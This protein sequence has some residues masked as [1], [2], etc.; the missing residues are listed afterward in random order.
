MAGGLLEQQ[1]AGVGVLQRRGDHFRSAF[2]RRLQ[3]V[4]FL[5]AGVED[6]ARG[7]DPVADP[8]RVGERGQRLLPQLFVFGRAVDQV[9]GV[10][11]HRFDLGGVHRLAEGGEI[12][13]AVVG[14]PPHARALV[15]DLDRFATALL[16][17]LD[18]VGEAAGGGNVRSDRT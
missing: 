13:L 5:R 18:R 3:R 7:A 4:G 12:L 8:Q 17:A 2:Q 16:A 9:D 14:R 6:D 11:D 10:D 1:R 15:E